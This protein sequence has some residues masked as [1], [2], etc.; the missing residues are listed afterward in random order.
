MLVV[1]VHQGNEN[2]VRV[3]GRANYNKVP[4]KT[5]AG[6]TVLAGLQQGAGVALDTV[7]NAVAFGKVP[8]RHLAEATMAPGRTRDIQILLLGRLLRVCDNV[9]AWPG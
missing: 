4:P 9:R 1:V 7:I 8:M 5:T 6:A 3:L 2:S